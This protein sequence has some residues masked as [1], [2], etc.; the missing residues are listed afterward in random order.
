MTVQLGPVPPVAAGLQSNETLE[1]R[2]APS[3]GIDRPPFS[4]EAVET[5]RAVDPPPS[6]ARTSGP[7]DRDLPP[8]I[9]P[10]PQAP[11]GPPPAFEASILDRARQDVSQLDAPRTEA[12]QPAPPSRDQGTAP[13]PLAPEASAEAYS[14]PPSA[15]L[16]AEVEL[17]TVRRIETP[18]D[19]ATVDVSR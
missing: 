18:Y 5:A 17:A 15:E 12:A 19:T 4:P 13:E 7:P 16:R 10:D 6:V 2:D 3:A 14:V 11:A 9:P 8:L 1:P